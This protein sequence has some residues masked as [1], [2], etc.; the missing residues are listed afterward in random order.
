MRNVTNGSSETGEMGGRFEVLSSEFW[1]LDSEFLEFRTSDRAF[2]ARLSSFARY[3]SR[4]SS[5]P[6]ADRI[7][8]RGRKRQSKNIT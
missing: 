2:L 5:T 7:C 6:L 1:V 4:M 3:A 8:I